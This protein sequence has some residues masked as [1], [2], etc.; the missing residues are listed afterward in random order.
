MPRQTG[1][2]GFQGVRAVHPNAP[3]PHSRGSS[4]TCEG[5]GEE[6]APRCNE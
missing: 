2:A 3:W 5:V 4:A 1:L 6:K